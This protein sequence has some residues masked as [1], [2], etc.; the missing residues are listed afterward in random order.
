LRQSFYI[1]KHK[2]LAALRR[3]KI[4]GKSCQESAAFA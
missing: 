2:E 4:L 1:E 3:Q